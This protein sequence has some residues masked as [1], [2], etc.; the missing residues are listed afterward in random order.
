[1]QIHATL[2][3]KM[4]NMAMFCAFLVVVIHCRPHF[5]PGTF[6][7]WVKQL[8]EEGITRVA[9]P[10]FFT[11]SGFVA[12]AKFDGDGYRTLVLKRLR[13]LLLPFAIWTFLFWLFVF[14]VSSIAQKGINGEMLS[15][16]GNLIKFAKR[17]GFWPWGFPFL[18]PLWYVRAL[19]FLTLAFPVLRCC[20]KKFGLAWLVAMFALY[21]IRLVSLPVTLWGVI[22]AFAGYGLLPVEGLFYYSLGIW[23]CDRQRLLFKGSGI[24]W[25]ESLLVGLGLAALRPMASMAGFRGVGIDITR[26]LMVPFLLFGVWGLM[27]DRRLPSWFVSCSFAIYLIHKFILLLLKFVWSAGDGVLQYFLMAVVAFAVSL[28][29]AVGMH[30]GM[31]KASALLFGGR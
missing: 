1:M 3:S 31:P 19:F 22:Q 16:M 30:S 7:W 18:S 26:H 25:T 17:L 20:V 4:R 29:L 27:S 10:Y 15:S 13:T 28:G 23:L 2:S 9:V 11:A 5:E 6:A 12:A 21:G 8:T 24:W 14:V